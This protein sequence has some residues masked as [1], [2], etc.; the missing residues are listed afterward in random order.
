MGFRIGLW[1]VCVLAMFGSIC[2]VPA[3]V[4]DFFEADFSSGIVYRFAPNGTKTVFASG[5]NGPEGLAQDA[6]GNV[7]V[8]ETGTGIIYKYTADGTSRTPFA[9]GLNGPASLVFDL[10]GNLW[11]A[12]FLGNKIYKFTPN[13]SRTTFAETGLNGPANLAFDA[14][15]NLFVADFFSGNVFKYAPNGSRTPFA[16]NVGMPHG[17]AFDAGGNLFVADFQGGIIY[18]FTP[19]ATRTTFA[20]SLDGPHGIAFDAAG[21]LFSCDYN[22][23]NIYRFTPAGARTTFA[24]MLNNPGNVY[25][26]PS[27]NNLLNISTRAF[28]GTGTGVLIGGF[29]IQ[30]SA[31][32]TLVVRAIGPS[33]STFFGGEALEDPFLEIFDSSM[34]SLGSNDNWESG[35]D[36]AAIQA[37]GLAPN[38]PLE[39][40][41]R[42]TLPAGNYTA[43]VKGVGDPTFV[44]G[45]QPGLTG[46]G[47]V[48]VYD[49]QQSGNRAGN[50][51][52]RGTV[53]SG[54]NVMIAGCI[55]GGG[56]AKEI[57]ARGIGP[58]LRDFGVN[59]ALGNP[60]LQL[61]NS[62]GS[63]LAENDDWEQGPD[64]STIQNRG[65]AP[66]S[67]LESALLATLIPGAYTVI[68]SPAP[69]DSGVG[70]I[71][72][73][74]VSP[75]N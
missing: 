47:L 64:A 18:R 53:L 46:I 58:S 51:A 4:G 32:S 23:G 28:V 30:G 56:Q 35:P 34:V 59:D 3:A 21:N 75:A 14:T 40:A 6:A 25:F 41:L 1:V 19:A 61:F 50:I 67:Q 74:D 54:Q 29:I 22:S 24:S 17:L 36:A 9:T 70:L 16:G 45:F 44:G 13:G 73:Y 7:F 72:I 31:Q 15:G 5:L 37:A 66:G 48:E 71:E 62:N 39:S 27:A 63:Q 68:E 38:H 69:Q 57:I 33:L 10:A 20:S 12:D 60:R 52:T 26:Q 49:L 42:I 2:S 8:S 65:F 11:D 55:I 43:V